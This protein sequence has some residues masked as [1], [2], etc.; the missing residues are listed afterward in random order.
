V[1]DPRHDADLIIAGAGCAGLS[2]LWYVL[3]SQARSRRVI[4]ID[5]DLG[6]GEDRSWAFW[7]NPSSPF[8]HLADHQWHRLHV[9][10]ATWNHSAQL[11]SGSY[12]RVRRHRYE[13]AILNVAA[14]NANIRF[15]HEPILDIF[16]EHDSGVVRTV[17]GDIRAPLVL[18]SVRMSP[19]DTLTTPRHPLRQHFGGWEVRTEHGVFD[20]HVATLMDFDTNQHGAVAFFYVL[21]TAPDRALV[22]HTMFSLQALPDTFHFDQVRGHLERLGAGTIEIENTE[23]GVIPMEDRVV[24]QRAGRHVWNIGVVGGRTKPTTGYTFQRIHTQSRHLINSWV[25]G[26]TPMPV[27]S[28][29][30]RYAFADRTLLSILHHRPEL[31]RPIFERLF[32]TTPIERV[33][34][35][36]DEES[37]LRHDASMIAGLPWVPFLRAATKE[38]AASTAAILKRSVRR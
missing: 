35:F 5:H 16:D 6:G 34:N 8:M 27:P 28:A 11:V 13:S 20:P 23:Y 24:R 31:G 36:L 9:H 12:A 37:T 21:P 17:S 32:Q 22:E 3:H 18:Q 26:G 30:Q 33:L 15:L 25:S 4:V 2:A 14:S 1:T 10:F 38:V 19:D 29:S 7:G